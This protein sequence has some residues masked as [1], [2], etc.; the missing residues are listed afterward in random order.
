MV[1]QTIRTI[2]DYRISKY[3]DLD[4]LANIF[5][6]YFGDGSCGRNR[7]HSLTLIR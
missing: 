3:E 7:L 5:G 4:Q 6:S 1:E 2:S